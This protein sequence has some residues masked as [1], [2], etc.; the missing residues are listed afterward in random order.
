MHALRGWQRLWSQESIVL[1]FDQNN[2]AL[3]NWDVGLVNA[4][5]KVSTRSVLTCPGPAK[6]PIFLYG[7]EKCRYCPSV[8]GVTFPV[9]EQS[10][11]TIAVSHHF[12]AFHGPTFMNLR[13]A[14][15][16][17]YV[18]LYLLDVVLSDFL[19]SHGLYFFTPPY[20]LFSRK[21]YGND[22]TL[23]YQRPKL[24]DRKYL[25]SKEFCEFAGLKPE[26]PERE[27]RPHA[28]ENQMS[29]KSLQERKRKQLKQRYFL[30]ERA[31]LGLTSMGSKTEEY[32]DKYGT[33]SEFNRRRQIVRNI[34]CPFDM[35]SIDDWDQRQMK[36]YLKRLEKERLRREM[37]ERALEQEQEE[38]KQEEQ[39]E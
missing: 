8:K 4:M 35:Y 10:V 14:K 26:V 37:E 29:E 19:F 34:I 17:E 20:S 28:I 39:E 7:Q 9:K 11:Q 1:L 38:Q 27:I 21:S 24:W 18:P 2:V 6:F 31:K 15:K 12:V 32:L 30:T 13:K 25:L 16:R 5:K 33:H 23:H 36:K 3:E 22:K